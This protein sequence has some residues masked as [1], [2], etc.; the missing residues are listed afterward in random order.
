[1]NNIAD[2]FERQSNNE[3]KHFLFV[4]KG[5]SGEVRSKL[6]AAKDLDKITEENFTDLYS[7]AMEISKILSGL[8][9]TLW[10]MWTL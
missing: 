8:I 6:Y 7:P 4:T 3:L 5:S 9:K 1:M 10:T 2:G